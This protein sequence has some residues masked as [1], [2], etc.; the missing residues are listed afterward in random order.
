MEADH[1]A[2]AHRDSERLDRELD[3]QLEADGG[4]VDLVDEQL[5]RGTVGGG[6]AVGC[7]LDDLR[8]AR[9]RERAFGGC[10]QGG[11]FAPACSDQAG[12]VD[13]EEP[14]G[15]GGDLAAGCSPPA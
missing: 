13:I 12:Q 9:R 5:D 8:A 3:T 2:V 11:M 10:G 1:V 15:N 6:D 7:K 4:G 14:V